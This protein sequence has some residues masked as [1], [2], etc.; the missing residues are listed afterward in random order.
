[1][2][3]RICN[4]EPKSFEFLIHP[5]PL[6]RIFRT[7]SPPYRGGSDGYRN[8]RGPPPP[9]SKGG[10]TF[11]KLKANGLRLKAFPKLQQ[12]KKIKKMEKIDKIK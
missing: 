3:L 7:Q 6:F 8:R 5:T 12:K 1:L 4:P 9:T 2:L 11:P 10:Q